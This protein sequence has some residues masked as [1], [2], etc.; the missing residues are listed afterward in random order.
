MSRTWTIHGALKE[1]LKQDQQEINHVFKELDKL[2]GVYLKYRSL[3]E[4]KR[5]LRERIGYT[6]AML[7]FNQERGLDNTDFTDVALDADIEESAEELKKKLPL[8]GAIVQ[9]LRQKGSE[10]QIVN[11]H[12]SLKWLGMGVTRQAIES[13]LQTH[14]E[15]FKITRRGRE[16]FVSLKM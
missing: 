7:S 15:L 9:V 8:W 4:K 10:M 5:E 1:Q 6:L 16:K 11:L 3:E 13:A 12:E 14:R 2:H